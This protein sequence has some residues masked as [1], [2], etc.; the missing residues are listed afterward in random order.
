MFVALVSW[1]IDVGWI[2]VIVAFSLGTMLWFLVMALLVATRER[3]RAM[4]LIK[5]EDSGV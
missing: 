1:T 2:A 5:K 4:E 3:E